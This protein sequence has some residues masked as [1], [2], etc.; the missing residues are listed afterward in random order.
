MAEMERAADGPIAGT[1]RGGV[2]LGVVGL[3]TLTHLSLFSGIGG[4][5]LAAEWAGFETVGQCEWADYP[6]KV[7][8]K[9]WPDVP[10]WRDIHELTAENFRDRT[11]IER[12]ILISAGFPRQP[13]SLAGKRKGTADERELWGECA[14]VIRV[15]KPKWILG[16]NVPGLLSSES[17]RFFG[18]ILRDLAN[19]GYD[20]R[21]CMYPAAWVGAGHKR[22]R[23]FFV[24]NSASHRWNSLGEKQQNKCSDVYTQLLETWRDDTVNLL[25]HVERSLDNPSGGVQRNDNGFSEGVE[26]LKCLGNAVVPQQVYPILAAIA[27]VEAATKTTKGE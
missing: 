21:W 12:P 22:E 15:L 5:D 10:R 27:E 26:R 9:H 13:H 19:M 24:S 17:G 16:E 6:T 3:E 25:S 2:E 23:V 7:L 4:V 1:L 18:R 11:G 14:R 20:A 8:E